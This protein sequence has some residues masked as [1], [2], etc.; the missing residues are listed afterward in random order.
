MPSREEHAIAA[1]VVLYRPDASVIDNVASYADQVSRVFAVDNSEQPEPGFEERLTAIGNVTYTANGANL[2]IATA[3]NVG[4]RTAIA[5][6]YDHLLTM[7]QDSTATPGMVAALAECMDTDTGIG[8]VS[9]VHQQ[10]GGIPRVV[11][12]G[13]RDVL[14][15]MTSG[16]LVRAE[17][18]EAVEGFMDELFIDQVD[19]EF[20]LHLH[21]AGFRVVETGDATLVHRVGDVRKHH[22]PYPAYSMNHSALRRYYIARN[23]FTVGE[24]Y[25]SE[26]PEFRAFELAE[27][28]KDMVKIVL[29]EKQKRLKL[30]MISRGIRDYRRGV[31]GPYPGR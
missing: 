30:R 17:A 21:R 23:R 12:A 8:L 6:G 22:F 20:C 15:A 31:L 24:M 3:L 27:L 9:P 29:Y 25:R 2:G 10:V 4:V 19:N 13:C 5:E 26:Y 16:N 14:T 7:D 11:D 18:Y 28:R 1:V